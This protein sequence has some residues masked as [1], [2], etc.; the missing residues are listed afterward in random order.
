MKY[1]A[2]LVALGTAALAAADSTSGKLQ[3][4]LAD[5]ATGSRRVDVIVRYTTPP[6]VRLHAIARKYGAELRGEL[7]LIDSAA[8]RMPASQLKRF[9]KRPEVVTISPDQHVKASMDVTAATVGATTAWTNYGLTGKG[10]GIAVIDSGVAST[11]DLVDSTGK[12]HVVYSAFVRSDTTTDD[13]AGHGT[14]VAGII[15]GD[16]SNSTG[17]LYTRTFRGI[18][19]GANIINIA[20][21]DRYSNGTDSNVI[22]G[23]QKA[24]ALKSTY[25]IRVINLSLGRPVS[26]SYKTD[27]LCQAVEAA[28]KA[29]IVVVVA[30]GNEGRN[31]SAGTQGYGTIAAPGNDPYVITVGAMKTKGTVGRS[32]DA[33]ASYS[34]KGPTLLDH[35]A[36][37]DL[38]AP[39]NQI[40]S[41]LAQGGRMRNAYSDNGVLLQYFERTSLPRIS[42]ATSTIG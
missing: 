21:L 3:G 32:D 10:I 33:I 38:V 17:S 12:N 7:T 5:I 11:A 9:A 18:A 25:N 20:V 19:P 22:A 29:G 34:S 14:H 2:L 15:A 39:G 27:P 6:N 40:V 13:L 42:T 26:Q 37:P 23:I 41:L 1:M 24:V 4:Q 31:N 28:W 16:A 30:A 36:K 35:V 8:Y